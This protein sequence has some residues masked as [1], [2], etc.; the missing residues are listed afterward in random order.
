M[1]QTVLILFKS[2]KGVR[3]QNQ[4]EIRETYRASSRA[5]RGLL[6]RSLLSIFGIGTSFTSSAVS[7]GVRRAPLVGERNNRLFP[8]RRDTQFVGRRESQI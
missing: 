7:V 2:T 1:N 6:N 3:Y 8:V 5:V 4:I